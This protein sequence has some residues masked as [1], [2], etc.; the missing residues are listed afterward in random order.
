MLR[1]KK[2]GIFILL[3]ML[4]ITF[5]F[6]IGCGSIEMPDGTEGGGG[7]N[8]LP[9]VS[10]SSVTFNKEGES[11]W[12]SWTEVAGAQSY[13]VKCGS[14]SVTTQTPLVD[15]ATVSG[16]SMPT[17]GNKIT[18]TIIAKCDGYKNSSPTS[19]TYEEGKQLS[20]PEILSFTNGIITWRENNNAKKYTVK[21]D[22]VKAAEST[23]N[24]FD[25]TALNGSVKIEIT[26]SNGSSS[27]TLTVMYNS[28][29]GKLSML[30]VTDYIVSSD[31]I[32]WGAVGGA[33]G[34]KVV[35][36]DFNS[37]VVTTTHYIMSIRNLVYGVYPVMPATSVVESAEVVP[38]DIKYLDGSGTAADPYI[39]K[40]PFDLRAIDYYE[41]KSTEAGTAAK[42]NYKIANDID[43]NT[44]S[45]L[46]DESNIFTLRKPF[47]G[48]L[49]GDNCTLSNMEVHYNYGFWALFEH[50]ATGGVVKNIKFDNAEMHNSVQD[51]EHPV[52]PATAMVAYRN[53][54]EVS[55][56]TLS[57]SK[58][59][60][61]AGSAAGL[62]I[63]NYGKITGCTVRNCDLVENATNKIGT[64]AYEMAGV[65]LENCKGG[66]VSGCTVKTLNIYGSGSNIGSS[67]GIVSINRAG[68]TV[69]DNSYD[70]VTVR[71]LKT[72]K[73]AGGVV[74]YCASSVNVT[75]G[76]GTLGT[77]MVGTTNV[78]AETGNATTPH[79]KLYGKQG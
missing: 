36:L 61:T 6:A 77:L 15:L 57:N 72:G 12:V 34:Y 11:F 22:G 44:V 16:F 63:H 46:E 68:A 69:K 56:V 21:V 24:T 4:C 29:S 47:F 45:A 64:A 76:S 49:D 60:V 19:V 28:A 70:A 58:F 59:N 27:A 5:A 10:A 33:S 38:V 74:A 30:P 55:A 75:K 51:E 78:T 40:T 53:Y 71:N 2:R 52:N 66:E 23:S 25:V 42:N 7:G 31:I 17:S 32:R 18:V 3:V 26:A 50:I 65:A 1:N 62:V 79:G 48:V 8:K 13:E 54:G 43:Y 37:Y 20:S 73:E 35:D 39:I 14:A 67:A 9:A 41:Y